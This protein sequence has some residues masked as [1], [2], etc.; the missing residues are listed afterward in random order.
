MAAMPTRF[1]RWFINSFVP[2]LF[3]RVN[4]LVR[5]LLR[6]RWYWP[7]SAVWLAVR[8]EGRRSRRS[9]EVPL[10]YHRAGDGALESIT[11]KRGRWWRNLDDGELV[12]V[13]HGGRER[14][15]RLELVVDDAAAIETA[16]RARDLLRRMLVDVPA[17]EAV[18]LRFHLL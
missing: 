9:Y 16:M 18:L 8:F 12:R 2:S 17:E 15:A 3:P 6:S 13:V 5:R 11:S 14:A 7:A 4:P 1:S 10:A